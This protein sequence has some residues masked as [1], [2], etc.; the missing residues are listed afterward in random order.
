MAF[1]F[2]QTANPDNTQ[3]FVF[4]MNPGFQTTGPSDYNNWANSWAVQSG[5]VA[6]VPLPVAVQLCGCGVLG[7]KGMSA[8]RRP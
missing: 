4:W 8:R 1:E 5:D 7:L 3:T 6:A 2:A